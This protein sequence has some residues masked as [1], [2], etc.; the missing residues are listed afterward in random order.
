ML[1]RLLARLKPPNG[2][3]SNP[4][5]ASFIPFLDA[6]GNVTG[7]M[8]QLTAA[9]LQ[10]TAPHPSQQ[11]LDTMLDQVTRVRVLDDGMINGKAIGSAV[12]LECDDPPSLQLLQSCLAIVEDPSSFGHC[13]CLGDTAIECYRDQDL[14]ATL[15]LHHGRSIHWDIWKHDTQLRDGRALLTWLADRGV[16]GPLEAYTEQQQRAAEAREA[17]QRWYEAMPDCLQPF[18]PQMQDDTVNLEPLRHAL[19][20]AYPDQV[21]CASVLFAWFGSGAG[22]WSGFPMYERVAEQ[23]LLEFPTDMLLDALAHH[24]PTTK[25]IDGAARYFAGWDFR[26]QKPNDLQRL[27]VEVKQ[28]LLMHSVDSPDSAKVQRARKAFA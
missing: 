8:D 1:R 15:G 20:A 11:T 19:R 28:R 6:Q 26:T 25:H 3:S 7:M 16:A 9:Y 24:A 12:L 5:D 23:L 14:L 13:M 27:P 21:I 18:W 2:E 10:S 22:P 4:S 17:A